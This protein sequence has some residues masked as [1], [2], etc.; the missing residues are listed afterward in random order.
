[1]RDHM[2]RQIWLGGF[3]S[4]AA[5]AGLQR[6]TAAASSGSGVTIVAGLTFAQGEAFFAQDQGFF[7]SHGLDTIV[8]TV[9]SGASGAAAVAGNDA[10]IGVSNILTLAEARSHNVPFVVIAPGGVHDSRFGDSGLLVAAASQI[11]SARE[12]NG[13]VI[14]VQTLNALDQLAV[15]AFIDKAGGNSDTVKFVEIP[16]SSMV[17]ALLGGRIV[18]AAF[19]EPALS[20]ALQSG[21]VR[22]LGDGLDTIGS[23][24][25][26]TAWYTTEDW[27]AANKDV[28]RRFAAA[29]Y[30]A[31]AWAME[32]PEQAASIAQKY[33][34]SGAL[35]KQRFATKM[36]P[37][38][39]QI[40]F[41]VA[42][43]YK[44]IPITNAASIIW[45]GA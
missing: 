10:H 27:L 16:Q 1:M 14:G 28:A 2:T 44:T 13:N 4:A 20:I 21:G 6:G 23:R 38:E 29:I 15:R 31:G 35:S 39:F 26:E 22:S 36:Q 8:K 5:T 37:A 11:A 25:V 12:F 18:A 24:F 19:D 41:D 7:R 45:T 40:L 43:R 17:D 34:K 3:A 32:Q 30:Q 9:N 33:V 42:A